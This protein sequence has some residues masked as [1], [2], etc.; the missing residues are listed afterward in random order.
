MLKGKKTEILSNEEELQNL[1][2]AFYEAL[3]KHKGKRTAIFSHGYAITF[4]IMKWSKI[5]YV[6]KKD[7]IKFTFKDKE[8]FNGNV[9]VLEVFK[10]EFDEK[11]E[12]IDIKNI[13]F[14]AIPY[15]DGMGK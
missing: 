8:I 6:E 1:D 10:L 3:E 4:F 2:A 15:K 11:N 14:E 5:E 9:N 12:L 7:S 13:E